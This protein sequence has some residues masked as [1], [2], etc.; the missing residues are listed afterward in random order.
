[1][2]VS[3]DD[4]YSKYN[5]RGGGRTRLSKDVSYIRLSGFDHFASPV[6]ITEASLLGKFDVSTPT[7]SRLRTLTTPSQV[8][9]ATA[10]LNNANRL[11]QSVW[12]I[13]PPFLANLFILQT[14]LSPKQLFIEALLFLWACT[15][16]N[17]VFPLEMYPSSSSPIVS[18][19]TELHRKHI[20]SLVS[21]STVSAVPVFGSPSDATMSDL[22]KNISEQILEMG[23][24]RVSRETSSSEKRTSFDN[25]FTSTQNMILNV[26][27]SNQVTACSAEPSDAA[28]DFCKQSNVAKAHIWLERKL[29]SDFQCHVTVN[30]AMVTNLYSVNFLR[31]RADTPSNVSVFNMMNPIPNSARSHKE[32]MMLNLKITHGKGASDNDLTAWTKQV[33]RICADMTEDSHAFRNTHCCASIFFKESS[34]IVTAIKSW[35]HHIA[36]HLIEYADCAASNSQFISMLV[37]AMDTRLHLWLKNCE[38]AALDQRHT[39][40]PSCIR[41]AASSKTTR[42]ST[43][44][45]S[46]SDD[47][48]AMK[49]SK[50]PKKSSGDGRQ[51]QNPDQTQDWVVSTDIYKSK[52]AGKILKKRV[53]WEKDRFMCVRFHTLGYCFDDSY[54]QSSHVLKKSEIPADKQTAFGAFC[55]LCNP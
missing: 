29:T 15:Q 50:K 7:S 38:E 14:D 54:N 53:K 31:S 9:E 48:G 37:Y 55:K 28:K 23:R 3:F 34:T 47:E 24:S 11:E 21:P 35:E 17:I 36:S 27:S 10:P 40:F 49:L 20:V 13:L 52:F 25:L 30:P 39:K 4:E 22:S 8:S 44:A 43:A 6:L 19:S 42:K 33:I 51:V 12:M 18:W 1:M 16:G 41:H 32:C 46:N 5:R 45:D 26:S 2:C